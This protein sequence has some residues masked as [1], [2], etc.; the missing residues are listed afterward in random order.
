MWLV[1]DRGPVNRTQWKTRGGLCAHALVT[2]EQ[3]LPIVTSR[4]HV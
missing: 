4:S 1:Q 2:E 3:R